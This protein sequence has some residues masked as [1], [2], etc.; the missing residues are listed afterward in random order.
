MPQELGVGIGDGDLGTA[1][2]EETKALVE[3][4]E[5]KERELADV[6]EHAGDLS[7][8]IGGI[9]HRGQHQQRARTYRR[10][11]VDEYAEGLAKIRDDS[12]E[13]RS[14][15][16]CRERAEEVL[17]ADRE[18]DEGRIVARLDG[19]QLVAVDV[20]DRCPAGCVLAKVETGMIGR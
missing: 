3:L 18:R 4:I 20:T 8:A 13:N 10:D 11:S 16:L 17:A 14:I 7:D 2:A 5:R 6:V 9:A 1:T 12:G 15:G 19:E